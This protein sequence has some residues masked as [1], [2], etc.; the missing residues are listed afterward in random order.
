MRKFSLKLAGS[1]LAFATLSIVASVA[2]FAQSYRYSTYDA[3][4]DAAGLAVGGT[5]MFVYFCF[6]CCV[7]LIISSICAFVVHKDA[8]KN[9]VE[10]AVL[11][12]A[13]SFFF[14]LIGLLI[15]FLAIKPEAL[16]NGG[17]NINQTVNEVKAK[18]EEKVEDV[19]EELEK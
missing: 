6:I 7:P 5:M 3:S 17:S 13:V 4:A 1:S 11:W 10:N 16:R 19:K 2:T 15:Y 8:K 18:V 14:P 12:T 9:N